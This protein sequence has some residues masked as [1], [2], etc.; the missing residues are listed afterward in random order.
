MVERS[1]TSFNGHNDT[2][3]EN[4]EPTIT[5]DFAAPVQ[6]SLTYEGNPYSRERVDVSRL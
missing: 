2:N 3:N 5:T 6:P 4:Q 1:N